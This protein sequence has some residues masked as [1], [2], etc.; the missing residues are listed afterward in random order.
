MTENKPKRIGG[1]KHTKDWISGYRTT[2]GHVET[3]AD[4]V[5]IKYFGH[6]L[7]V[8]KRALRYHGE[9]LIVQA[10]AIDTAKD[11]ESTKHLRDAAKQMTVK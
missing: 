4:A 3:R 6:E 5:K 8:P 2:Q 7:W 10:W 9:E 1:I 11:Y